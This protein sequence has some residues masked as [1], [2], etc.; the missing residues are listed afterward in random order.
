MAQL[1][2][3]ARF[4]SIHQQTTRLVNCRPPLS[5]YFS[6]IPLQ[7]KKPQSLLHKNRNFPG[8]LTRAFD[9]E[10]DEKLSDDYEKIGGGGGGEVELVGDNGSSGSGV[11]DDKYPDGE[12]VYRD[13][14]RWES[15][16]VKFRMLVALPWER[17]KKGSVL[18][19]KIRGEVNNDFHLLFF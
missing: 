5:V 19:M 6:L 15:L 16:V 9:T 13:Y 14:G 7:L 17:V 11:D 4:T 1:L 10:N 8:F 3:T 12:F 18:M 2:P